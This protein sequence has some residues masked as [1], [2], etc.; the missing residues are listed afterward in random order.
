MALFTK[1]QFEKLA[2]TEVEYCISIYIPT[3]RN[4]ENK[5]SQIRLKN[6][7][8]NVEKQLGEFG[9]KPKEV[10]EYV[11][12]LKELVDDPN[13]WR[14][15]SDA[16]A[17]FRTKEKFEYYNL[18]LDVN[19]FSQ[20]SDR[21]YLLPLMNIFNQDNL[22]FILSLSLHKNRFYEATQH[23]ITEIKV[24]DVFPKDIYDSAGHD[25]VQKSLEFRS[26]MPGK[27]FAPFHGKGE[28]K[29]YKETEVLK[30]MEDLDEGLHKVLEGYSVP[31]VV[32]AVESIFAQ[33]K[34][35]SRYKNIVPKCVP[36]NYDNGD[37]L[38][39]H[40][41][42]KDIMAPWFEQ[43]KNDKKASYSEAIGKT[44]SSLEDVV[45]AADAGQIDTLFVAK[46]KHVWGEYDREA[47]KINIHNEK[48]PMDNCLLDFAARNTFLKNGKVFFE[49]EENLPENTSPVN[50]ILRF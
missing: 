49:E 12:P 50:A 42:A 10:A 22:F 14:H 47:A 43:V 37:I 17:V 31:V 9:L 29:D 27:E 25:V 34:E 15:L 16:M 38:T 4:G 1:N 48:Q 19:E 40:E 45:I 41:K 21:F 23:E 46:G 33:F 36:G 3:Y 39:V 5:D 32:A 24:D 18:P 35:V 44:T 8:S 26:K 20:V 11:A 6:Q 28:G 7:V 13:I 2:G 30:Y